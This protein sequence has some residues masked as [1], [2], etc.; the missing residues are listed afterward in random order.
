LLAPQGVDVDLECE[1][2]ILLATISQTILEIVNYKSQHKY[3]E[4]QSLP[5]SSLSQ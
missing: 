1:I 3:V 4:Y 5:M 2:I